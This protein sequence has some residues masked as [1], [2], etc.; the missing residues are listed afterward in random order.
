MQNS[1]ANKPNVIGLLLAAGQ[2]SRFG[3]HKLRHVLDNGTAMGLQSAL[4]LKETVDEVVCVVR[5]DDSVL[6]DIF[7]QHGFTTIENPEH[8]TGLSSSI[9][10]GIQSRSDADYWLIALGDMPYIQAK[11]YDAIA[12]TVKNEES[13]APN[14]RAIIRPYLKNEEGT[15]KKLAGHPVAFPNRYKEQLLALKGDKGAGA[16][17]KNKSNDPNQSSNENDKSTPDIHWL[18]VEDEGILFDIDSRDE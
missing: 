18:L 1:T 12:R 2:G 3:G 8:L 9:R 5:P 15:D 4:N 11:T 13:I 16:L 17:F 10:M 14:N 6:I 7:K